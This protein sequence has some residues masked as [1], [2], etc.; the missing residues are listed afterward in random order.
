MAET[1]FILSYFEKEQ[2]VF[3]KNLSILKKNTGKK[4]VHDIRVAVKKIRAAMH[5]FFLTSEKSLPEDLLPRTDQLFSVLGKQRDI[6]IC[7]EIIDTFQKDAGKKYPELKKH[8]RSALAVTYKWTKNEVGQYKKK[9]L[10]NLVLMIK[11]TIS[12]I[13]EN[14]LKSKIAFII[15]SHL[16]GIKD[17]FKKPHKLRQQLKE[18]YYWIKMIPQALFNGFAYEKNLQQLLEDFGN[19]QNLVVFEIK[20]RH[21]R[22]DFLPKTFSEYG[23]IKLLEADIKEKKDKLLKISLSKTRRLLKQLAITEKEKP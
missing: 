8:F 22:K 21:F 5:L 19:W 9:E 16:A 3:N 2:K 15:N 12:G 18:I 10:A 1:G 4:A 23:S 11:N 13:E 20:L 6:E 17:L 7:I 14:E